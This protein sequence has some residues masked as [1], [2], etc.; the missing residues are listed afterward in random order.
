MAP[1]PPNVRRAPA[2]PWR[3]SRLLSAMMGPEMAPKPSLFELVEPA[4]A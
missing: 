1:K 3:S 4:F 2:Q